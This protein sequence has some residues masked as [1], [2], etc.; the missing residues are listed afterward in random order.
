[1]REFAWSCPFF[2]YFL[3]FHGHF[4]SEESVITFLLNCSTWDESISAAERL[5]SQNGYSLIT[6]TSTWILGG[7]IG[8]G[9]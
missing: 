6:S 5:V 3:S 7:L 4:W 8:L 2:L 9:L 1:M